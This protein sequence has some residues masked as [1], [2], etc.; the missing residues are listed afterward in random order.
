MPKK[1]PAWTIHCADDERLLLDCNTSGRGQVVVWEATP[2]RPTDP[3]Q[4]SVAGVMADEH[5]LL[6][7][8][9][10]RCHSNHPASIFA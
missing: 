2:M 6:L 3:R 5:M 7:F 1:S 4:R 9:R 8:N 10:S